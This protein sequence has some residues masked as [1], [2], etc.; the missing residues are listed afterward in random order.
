[1]STPSELAEAAGVAAANPG[2]SILWIGSNDALFPLL[3]YG[4]KPTDPL[5]FA[6][7]YRIAISTMRQTSK[8]LVVATIPDVTLTPYLTSVPKLAAALGL[9]P[10]AVEA[11]FGLGANDKVTPYA[12]AVIDQMKQAGQFGTL[13]PFITVEGS[14]APVVIPAAEVQ[15]IRQA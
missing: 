6:Y 9:S 1:T 11:T 8:Q 2:T 15:Q 3:F 7:L 12:F 14:P 10:Q 4:Q 13:P 5:T